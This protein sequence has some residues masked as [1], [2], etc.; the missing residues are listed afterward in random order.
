[1]N[2][3]H[4]SEACIHSSPNVKTNENHIVSKHKAVKLGVGELPMRGKNKKSV[5]EKEQEN[6]KF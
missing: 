5:K 3:F 2:T 4:I 6:L 1:M